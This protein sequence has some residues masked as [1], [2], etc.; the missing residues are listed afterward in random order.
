VALGY[1]ALEVVVTVTV[2][3]VE[4]QGTLTGADKVPPGTFKEPEGPTWPG[5]GAHVK[6]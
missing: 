2:K 3:L 1:F 4:P 6:V 5:A